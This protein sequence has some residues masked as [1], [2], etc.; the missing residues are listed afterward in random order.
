[1]ANAHCMLDNKA[2]NTHLQYVIF[3]AF[4][5]QQWLLERASMLRY[6]YIA[7]IIF[8]DRFQADLGVP[9]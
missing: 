8:D 5:Q 3:I 9:S 6:G 7:C 1:M 4:E 2:T